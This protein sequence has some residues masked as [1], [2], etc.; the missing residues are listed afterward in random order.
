MI[1]IEESG[2]TFGPFAADTLF[3]IEK[4]AHVQALS[5]IKV[6]EFIWWSAEQSKLVFVEAKSSVPNRAKSPEEYEKYFTEIWEKLE[7][8]LQI[9]LAASV[10][11]PT[12]LGNE[13]VADMANINWRQADIR[14]YLVVPKA[15]MEYLDPLSDKLTGLFRRQLTIWNGSAKVINEA[16][17]RKEGLLTSAADV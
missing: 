2:V 17:A 14:L 8:S 10:N 12:T 4:S 9:L 6:C 11:R 16:L 13:L 3:H 1:T 7:N 5:G 15:P